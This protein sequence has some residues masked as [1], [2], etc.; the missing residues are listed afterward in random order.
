MGDLIDRSEDL[1][2]LAIVDLRIPNNPVQYTHGE[3][4]KLI[5]SIA[6]YLTQQG[7]QQGDA[8]AIA[9]LNRTE[10]L[11]VYFGIMRA[12]F[13]AVPVNI[14]L[15]QHAIQ[16]ILKD[17]NI[18]LIFAEKEYLSVLPSAIPVIEFDSKA[19]NGFTQQIKHQITFTPVSITGNKIAQILYTSGSTGLP[20]GVPL[21][22]DGQ[23]WALKATSKKKTFHQTYLLAQPLF[24]MNGLFMSKRAFADNATLVILPK[25][26]LEHYLAAIDQYKV[27][28]ITAVPT[29][30][31]R[32][33]NNPALLEQ[34]DISSL[35]H[36]SLG[37]APITLSLIER[38]QHAFPQVSLRHGYGTTEAG[39]AVFGDHPKGIKAPRMSLGYP[40]KECLV[41]LRD[42]PDKNN[43]VL[44]IKNPAV[45]EAYRNLPEKTAKAVIDGWYNTGDVMR[46]DD[47]GFFFF[48]GR[49][50]DM[51]VC[52]AENIYPVE[53]EKML[54]SHPNIQQASVVPLPDEERAHVPVAF[55]I[56]KD[57]QSLSFEEIKQYAITHGPA[58]HYPRRIEIVEDLPWAGTNKVDRNQL[59]QRAKELEIKQQ[60]N[61]TPSQRKNA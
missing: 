21:S 33:L 37:S 8:I 49:A 12:G 18:K 36:L 19:D 51:F 47:N 13:V 55:I 22:H 38:I 6:N 32:I 29:M 2:Q 24:H 16:H 10:Y 28:T 40:I 43:G 7:L 60:W 4:D 44:Y 57:H 39:P 48:I 59:I 41:E 58:Y 17:A 26:Q 15:P 1:D 11:A 61:T 14:K 27:T 9:S 30:F 20:K 54:E 50:D 46:R 35:R 53:V 3:F 34:Y 31:A 52:A 42:G 5:N 25:F 45:L 23:L 56:T